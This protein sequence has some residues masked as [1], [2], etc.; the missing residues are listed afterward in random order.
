VSV[1]TP[2]LAFP[3]R[4][5]RNGSIAVLEQ[6]TPAHVMSC[7]NVIVRCPTGF[8][9]DKPEFGWPFPEFETAPI[10]LADLEAALRQFEPRGRASAYQWTEEADRSSRHISIDVTAYG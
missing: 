2:H 1:E 4:R 5:D 6:D 3:F 7:E 10:I 9:V 8:R